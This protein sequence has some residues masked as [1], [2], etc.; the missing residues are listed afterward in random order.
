MNILIT[1]GASGLGA[2][3]TRTLAK[4]ANNNIY[5]TYYSS[6]E[7]AEA[8]QKEFPN[9]KGIACDFSNEA[10]VTQLVDMFDSLSLDVLINN[11]VTGFKKNHF[12]KL[13][14]EYFAES[15]AI[16]IIPIIRI[17]QKAIL[18]FRKSKFGK[19][20]TVL[21]SSIL[22]KPAIGWSEYIAQKNYLLSL[23]KSW[24]NENAPFNITS[25]TISPSFMLTSL[26]SATDERVI[27]EIINKHPLKKIL[28]PDEVAESVAFLVGSTQHINGL[29]LVINASEDVI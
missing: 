11:A 29:N 28:T 9:S 21:S 1:G 18:H 23:S 6:H 15:F 4:Q 13:P 24:A 2:S 8:I 25:N 10:S 5:F 14:S 20:I 16:N 3:I 19:I 17:T 22:N 7:K 27:E 12:H 26:T